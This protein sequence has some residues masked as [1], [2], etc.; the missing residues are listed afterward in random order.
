MFTIQG[1]KIIVDKELR[2]YYEFQIDKFDEDFRPDVE[3]IFSLL[4]K[5]TIHVLPV[6][7]MIPRASDNIYASLIEYDDPKL[8]ERYL[9]EL[10]FDDP[11]MAGIMNDVLSAPNLKIESRILRRK[12]LPYRRTV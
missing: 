10:N 8:Y 2:K 4:S 9:Q 6:W 7:Y 5:V 12:I 1:D 3:Y 11:V